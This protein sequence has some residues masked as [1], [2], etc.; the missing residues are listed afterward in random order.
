[1]FGGGEIKVMVWVQ[2][3]TLTEKDQN[4]IEEY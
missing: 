3:F 4:F 2:D 1:M